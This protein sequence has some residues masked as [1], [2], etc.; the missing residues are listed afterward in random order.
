VDR[1]FV[2][3]KL[4][5]ITGRLARAK[6]DA[7]LAEELNQRARRALSEAVTGRYT[8]ANRELNAIHRRLEGH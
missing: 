4:T 6:L 5:R 1:A 7:G 8:E 2:D 3:A